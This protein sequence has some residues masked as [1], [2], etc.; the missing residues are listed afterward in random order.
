ME[1]MKKPEFVIG[2][3]LM[4][5]MLE[6]GERRDGWLDW[7]GSIEIA[8]R[9]TRFLEEIRWELRK[10]KFKEVEKFPLGTVDTTNEHKD[11]ID[12]P[13]MH[14]GPIFDEKSNKH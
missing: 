2:W 1:K 12:C 6:R 5:P 10:G 13:I 7:K 3:V 8:A 9:T 14:K 4:I 11:E